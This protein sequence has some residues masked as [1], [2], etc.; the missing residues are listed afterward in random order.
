MRML[1][2][3]NKH[4][5]G[6]VSILVTMVMMVVITLIVLG[7]A[8]VSRTEQRNATDQQLSTQA[9]YAAESGINDARAVINTWAQTNPIASLPNKTSCANANYPNANPPNLTNAMQ[10]IN[11]AN[12][13]YYTCLLITAN[14][15][16]LQ[17]NVSYNSTVIPIISSGA[18]I[19]SLTLNWQ[20]PSGLT[21]SGY[22]C[23]TPVGSFPASTNWSCNFPVLRVDLADTTTTPTNPITRASWSSSASNRVSTM[24]F[25]PTNTNSASATWGD[26]GKVIGVNCSATNCITTIKGLSDNQYYMRVTTL[27]LTGSPLTITDANNQPLYGAQADID[28][29][30]KAQDTL[31]RIVV[32]ADLSDAN[33]YAIPD[34]AII[35]NYSICKQFGVYSGYFNTYTT[36]TGGNPNDLLCA[37]SHN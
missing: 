33:S 3:N 34:A 20:P 36:Q 37:N 6:M 2:L 5:S 23:T 26:Q 15:T 18:A 10:T 14:P 32:A 27:Y 9:Y 4:Q 28:S 11:S 13:T 12:N 22:S 1:R 30:G 19:S 31:R 7:F 8:E 29:T 35:S 17:Y 25:L 24:F 21:G 16:A